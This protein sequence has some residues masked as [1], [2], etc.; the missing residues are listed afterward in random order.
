MARNRAVDFDARPVRPHHVRVSNSTDTRA[1]QTKGEQV[2]R[3]E[4]LRCLARR[5]GVELV[6]RCLSWSTT[7]DDR[8]RRN[9]SSI[10]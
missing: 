5:G 4:L 7:T 2:Q 8:P 1:M 9:L 3:R 6:L 10:N